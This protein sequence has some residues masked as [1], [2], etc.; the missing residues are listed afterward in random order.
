MPFN[1]INA[2]LVTGEILERANEAGSRRGEEMRA[3]GERPDYM[4]VFFAIL[5]ELDGHVDKSAI[6]AIMFRLQALAALVKDR[7]LG[8]WTMNVEGQDYSLVQ[9]AVFKAA[10]KAP[11]GHNNEIAFDPTEIVRLALELSEEEGS[12]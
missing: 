10:A 5:D 7:A 12:A 9:A 6:P 8:K 3:V 11:L 4:D 2:T 1:S